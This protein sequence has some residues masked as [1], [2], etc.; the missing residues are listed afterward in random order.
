[1]NKVIEFAE[2]LRR[3]HKIL[4]HFWLYYII[5]RLMAPIIGGW[6]YILSGRGGVVYSSFLGALCA[7]VLCRMI[8]R[9]YI[10]EILGYCI[11]NGVIYCMR[12]AI[13]NLYAYFNGAYLKNM[14]MLVIIIL[15]IRAYKKMSKAEN[16]VVKKR[17]LFKRKEKEVALETVIENGIEDSK[18]AKILKP[19]FCNEC[20]AEIPDGVLICPECGMK[21]E[22]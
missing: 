15:T 2:Q 12:D 19:H 11:G 13:Y 17:K 16:H 1:M 18:K 10:G 20:G 7:V 9:K 14:I 3:S 8:H 21:A 6:F 5:Y 4:Y 22:D